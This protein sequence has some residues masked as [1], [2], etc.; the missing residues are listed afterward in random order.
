MS[1]AKVLAEAAGESLSD[2]MVIGWTRDGE[3]Y[4]SSTTSEGPEV[5]WLMEQAKFALL[6][7]GRPE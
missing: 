3:M 2:C 1:P 5:L 7:M 4:F 6:E